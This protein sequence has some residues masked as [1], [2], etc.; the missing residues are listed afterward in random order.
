MFN[1]RD[2]YRYE[3]VGVDDGTY[4]L[5]VTRVSDRGIETFNAT[6]VP[7][8]T[9]V[10]HQYSIDWNVLSQG[11]K[12]V[13][14]KIDS[15]GDGTFEKTFTEDSELTHYEFASKTAGLSFWIWIAGGAGITLILVIPCI[16]IK[17]RLARK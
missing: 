8:G 1:A 5:N 9:R 6:N 14:L 16:L 11:E 7:T 12:G 4:G 15:D 10:V 2:S 13:T 17:C 3:V